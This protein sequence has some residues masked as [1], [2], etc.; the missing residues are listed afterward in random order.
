VLRRQAGALAGLVAIAIVLAGIAWHRSRAEAAERAAEAALKAKNLGRFTLRL[1]P[2]DW[3][4][5]AQHAIDVDAAR[6][7]FTWQL[8]TWSDDEPGKPFVEHDD[9][10]RGA[11]RLERGAVVQEV[12]AR[13]GRGFL[14]ITRPGCTRS[15]L[16]LE[17]LP[18]YADREHQVPVFEIH[19]PTCA[20]TRAGTV[21][22]PA[23]PFLYGGVGDPPSDVAASQ[24][25][26]TRE[27][28]L[29]LPRFRIEQTEVTNAAFGVFAAMGARTGIS[30]P[31][32]PNTDWLEP[33]SGPRRPV[34]GINWSTARAYCRYL[35]GDLPTSAQWVK[36]MRGGEHLPDGSPNPMPNR[37]YPF[38][39]GD[40]GKIAA[41]DPPVADVGTHLQD[42]SPYGVYDM[43]GN[44]EE[45]TLTVGDQP[46]I[47][48]I[49]GGG[50]EAAIR[51]SILDF[52]AI[53][54]RRVASQPL[55]AI[56]ERC[57][58]NE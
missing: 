14:A 27:Q 46:G 20:A 47:R 19:V 32:Y 3:D 35:G 6:L 41:L 5:I 9:F 13:G 1:E 58:V 37:N 57:V 24:P 26:Y 18:G 28:R 12:E 50:L 21:E 56:G 33:A 55:F 48:V 49:R 29:E 30:A 8:F 45:W 10:E 16:P 53:P 42:V 31:V 22:I 39:H 44:A 36:A 2:F 43:T 52:M 11:P 40:P 4:P 23:G 54:N 7:G 25:E 51:E 34:T 38:G 15:L 17:E